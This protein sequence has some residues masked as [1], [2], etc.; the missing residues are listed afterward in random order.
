MS[1]ESRYAT[2]FK[3]TPT[4]RTVMELRNKGMTNREIAAELGVA[5]NTVGTY[6]NSI[7]S[8][9]F[10]KPRKPGRSRNVEVQEEGDK[11]QNDK[12]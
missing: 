1:Q 11:I 5:Y 4:E 12:T 8:K 3:L 9:G 7:I 10:I 6:I 2:A